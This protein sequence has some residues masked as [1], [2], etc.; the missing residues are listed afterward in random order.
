M[1]ILLCEQVKID[2]SNCQRTILMPL[3]F[4]LNGQCL[5]R[6]L[7]LAFLPST[8]HSRPSFHRHAW[9]HYSTDELG[10]EVMKKY[11]RAFVS[12]H[13]ENAS[14]TPDRYVPPNYLTRQSKEGLHEDK[15]IEAWKPPKTP[16]E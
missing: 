6:H 12:P 3:K 2:M 5:V 15:T 16:Q 13:R 14:G 1:F 11:S 4:H 7:S 10:A 9:L 8:S